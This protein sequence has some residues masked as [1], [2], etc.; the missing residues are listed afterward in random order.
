[1]RLHDDQAQQTAFEAWND[2]LLYQVDHRA[3]CSAGCSIL[4]DVCDVG[5]GYAAAE[6]QR[7]RDY[8]DARTVEVRA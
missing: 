4:G 5:R 8:H 1:M 2:A 3:S 7:W 6:Q